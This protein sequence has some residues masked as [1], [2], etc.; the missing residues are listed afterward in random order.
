MYLY[1][2]SFIYMFWPKLMHGIWNA[3]IQLKIEFVLFDSGL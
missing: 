3:L 1:C 2:D